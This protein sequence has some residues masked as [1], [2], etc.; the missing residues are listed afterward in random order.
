MRLPAWT[1]ISELGRIRLA[2]ADAVEITVTHASGNDLVEGCGHRLM[3]IA[4][5]MGLDEGV[6]TDCSV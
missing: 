1:W 2:H 3:H 6:V 5:I 4:R